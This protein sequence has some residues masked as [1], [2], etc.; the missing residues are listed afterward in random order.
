[1]SPI[2]DFW[3]QGPCLCDKNDLCM[4][5]SHREARRRRCNGALLVTLLVIYLEFKAHLTNTATTAFCSDTSSHLVCALWGYH[6][7]FKRTMTQNTPPGCVRAIWPRRRVMVLHQMTWPPQ[8]PNL[9][10]I[11]MVWVKLDSRLKEKYANKCSAYV[12]TPSRLL[13]KHSSWYWLRE[14][15]NILWFV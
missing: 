12:G 13:E 10:P 11:E 8:L 14:W 15:Q 1:M 4:C 7:F 5:G 9:N 2:W 3:F 6:F